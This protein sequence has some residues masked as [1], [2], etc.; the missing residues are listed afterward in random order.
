MGQVRVFGVSIWYSLGVSSESSN[1]GVRL[2]RGPSYAFVR[3]LDTT[4]EDCLD[5]VSTYTSIVTRYV[6]IDLF[7]DEDGVVKPVRS[8]RLPD[9]IIQVC[10]FQAAFGSIADD[11]FDIN[12]SANGVGPCNTFLIDVAQT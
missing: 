8:N 12:M 1:S 6:Y 3:V 9:Q 10:I 7:V 11:H 4:H 2:L 5:L